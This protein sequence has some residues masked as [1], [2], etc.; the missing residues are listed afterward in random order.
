[1]SVKMMTAAPASSTLRARSRAVTSLVSAQPSTATLPPLASMPTAILPGN[2]RQASFTSAGFLS[3]A[4]PRMTRDVAA[5]PVL[6]AGQVADAAAELHRDLDALQDGV[7]RR[8][9]HRLACERAVEIDQ[10]QPLC[11][12]VREA[13]R[14]VGGIGIVDGGLLHVALDEAHALAVLE[15]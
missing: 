12:G 8:G 6:D 7:D 10:L 15:V 9:V 11:S 3:A 1:M 4:V 5:E 2:L 13:A 14:L